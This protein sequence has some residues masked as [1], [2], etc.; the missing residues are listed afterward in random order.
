MNR[1]MA[2]HRQIRISGFILLIVVLGFGITKS[3]TLRVGATEIHSGVDVPAY[4]IKK[5]DKV[6]VLPL[7]NDEK[8]EALQLL[9]ASVAGENVILKSGVKVLLIK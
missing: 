5:V 8:K 9:E 7:N 4:A 2:K 1:K 6:D 3:R